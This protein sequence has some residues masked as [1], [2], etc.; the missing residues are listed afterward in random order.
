MWSI[1]GVVST[2]AETPPFIGEG[3]LAVR[4]NCLV[5]PAEFLMGTHN[6][7]GMYGKQ[8]D[9]RAVLAVGVAV[10]AVA[11]ASPVLLSSGSDS[12]AQGDPPR[13]AARGCDQRIEGSVP[14]PGKRDTRIGPIAFSRLPGVY[15]YASRHPKTPMKSIAI[16]RAGARVRLTVPRGQRT[17]LR[18]GYG[19]SKSP[20]IILQACRHFRSRQARENECRWGAQTAC[21]NGPTLFSGGFSVDFRRAPR[22]GLCAELIIRVRGREKSLRKHLFK[23]DPRECAESG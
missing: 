2:S 7:A 16:V 21:A 22:R 8:M 1:A 9:A 19:A 23:P 10:V 4:G 11:S 6:R 17:W 5:G 13:V 12:S 14:A 18:V 3:I 20:K 15:R